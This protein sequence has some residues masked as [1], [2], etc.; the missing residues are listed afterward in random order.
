[1]GSG[2]LGEEDGNWEGRGRTQ[3]LKAQR[4]VCKLLIPFRYEGCP[5][6]RP[7]LLHPSYNTQ[8]SR[9]I[10][11]AKIYRVSSPLKAKSIKQRVR[12]R[13]LECI[14]GRCLRLPGS[15]LFLGGGF[16]TGEIIYHQTAPPS[17]HL[18]WVWYVGHRFESVLGWF[19]KLPITDWSS[20]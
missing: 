13:L 1:M 17:E 2:G 10:T 19:Q 7:N 5:K 16:R 15:K 14:Y 6:S 3:A 20:C 11:S 8:L 9:I 12:I 4:D 18:P